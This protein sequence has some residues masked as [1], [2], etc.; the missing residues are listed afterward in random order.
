MV[1][2][3]KPKM[4]FGYNLFGR[5]SSRAAVV[6]YTV[7]TVPGKCSKIIFLMGVDTATN[8]ITDFGGGIK[9]HE[10]DLAGAYREFKE[11][12]KDIFGDSISMNDLTTCLSVVQCVQPHAHLPRGMSV[13]F[14]PV[15]NDWIDKAEKLFDNSKNSTNKPDEISKLVWLDESEFYRLIHGNHLSLKMWSRLQKFYRSAYTP[16]LRIMLLERYWW[17]LPY[18]ESYVIDTG[19]YKVKISAIMY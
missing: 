2:S 19:S 10:C 16:S 3:I 13:I 18:R 5:H 12:T 1:L 4:L 7:K 17:F 15:S 11:E 14:V 9:K 8:D 6:P